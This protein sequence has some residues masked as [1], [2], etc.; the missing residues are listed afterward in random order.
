MKSIRI[1]VILLLCL[2]C[3]TAFAQQNVVILQNDY[4]EGVERTATKKDVRDITGLKPVLESRLDLSGTLGYIKDTTKYYYDF[5]QKLYRDHFLDVREGD[6]RLTIDPLIAFE[7][8][9]D[10]GDAT[11]YSDTNNYYQN[12]RGFRIT[13][14]LGPKVSFQTSFHETQTILP[15]YLFLN[16]RYQGVLSGQARVKFPAGAKMDYGFS[17]A[18]VSYSPAKW[19]NVQLGQGKHF[20]GHGYRSVLLSDNALAAPYYE[21][22]F[23]SNNKR[24]QYTT[25]HTKLQ[26]GV[27]A[28]DRLQTGASSESL[29][30]WMRARFHHLGVNLGR[31]ELGLFESTIFRNIDKNGVRPFDLLELNPL[32]GVNVASNGFKGPYKSLVGIDLKVKLYDNG[33]FYGQFAT[34]DPEQQ[35]YAWQAGVRLF[36][37]GIKRLNVQLE[38]NAVQPFMYMA[39]PV[40]LNYV[41]SGLAMAHPMGANFNEAVVIVDKTFKDRLRLQAKLNLALYHPDTTVTE[42][43]GSDLNRPDNGI[44]T[45]AGPEQQLFFMDVNASYLFNPKTNFR[46]TVGV[47]K[48]DLQEASDNVQSTYFYVVLGTS[49]FNR[50]Y[51]F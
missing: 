36:D 29:F 43:R 45:T 27:T 26:H 22:S 35:R 30:S 23:L 34:D 16:T 31:V 7:I 13:A 18:N 39:D 12:T 3:S 32:I 28:M 1:L 44:S 17:Q 47:R 15:Q 33:Y 9:F 48:R 10:P 37:L 11:L 20:V 41:N 6:A 46:F 40:Q 42:N 14:D 5:T 50:Y 25:W 49:I 19:F 24:W 38:Y 2:G 21:F 4:T 51:D 8:G